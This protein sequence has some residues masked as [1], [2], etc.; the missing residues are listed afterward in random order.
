V[1]LHNFK[2]KT[3]FGVFKPDGVAKLNI[4]PEAHATW[5]RFPAQIRWQ[6]TDCDTTAS[7]V[8]LSWKVSGGAM[9]QVHVSSGVGRLA[10]VVGHRASIFGGLR[11][12]SAPPPA[13][14]TLP[15]P[16]HPHHPHCPNSLKWTS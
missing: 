14:T 7:S 5:S 4:V 10:W 8:A 3:V 1:F 15:T 9:T 2:S 6:R 12:N 16:H 13:P 11:H